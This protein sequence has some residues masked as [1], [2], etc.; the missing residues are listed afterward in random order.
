M[1]KILHIIPGLATGGAQMMLYKL[2]SRTDRSRFE[3]T[4]VVLMN[5][6]TVGEMIESLGIPVYA[7]GLSRGK[8][9]IG[10]MLRLL[11]HIRRIKPDLVQGW[12]YHGNIA[13]SLSSIFSL[14][15]FPVLWNIRHSM[16]GIQYQKKNTAA[17]IRIGAIFSKTAS[18]IIYNSNLSVRQH[19]NLGY[20]ASRA[21]VIPNGFDCSVYRPS[22]DARRLLR[23]S[24]GLEE[25]DVLVGLI[26]RF[27]PQKDHSNYFQAASIL[28][29][30][31]RNVY[32]VL[33]GR[34]IDRDN[35]ALTGLI[36]QDLAGN[37]VHLLGERHDMPQIFSGLDI[38]C[39]SSAYGEAFPNIIGEA[40]ACA[41]PCVVTDIGDS[42]WIVGDT[43]F[44]VPAR[45][46]GALANSLAKLVDIGKE[47]RTLLGQK[48]RSRIVENFTLEQVAKQYE[49]LYENT[50]Q[51]GMSK[52]G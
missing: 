16:H 44:V 18:R 46:P 38:V 4:V 52:A 8:P 25:T 48:A 36:G 43:G 9:T 20:A 21:V 29:R 2:L 23:E 42:A 17:I 51:H 50:I 40:M 22:A 12:M 27:D 3:P 7:I 47:G 33:A 35:T 1:Q 5:K 39:S 6:S 49:N 30:Q 45:D 14:R 19:E 31:Y 26:A 28:A 24:L 10:G 13:A 37:K 11:T 41:V 15:S 34:G 32:F